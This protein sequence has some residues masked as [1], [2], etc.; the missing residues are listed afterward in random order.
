MVFVVSS[1]LSAAP[2]EL[3]ARL[4][5]WYDAG[6]RALPWRPESGG[7]GD[8]YGVWLSEVMLQQ[9]TVAAVIPYFTKFLERWPTL[10]DLA[11]AADADV[12]T[13]WAGLGYYSRAR[14]VLACARAVVAEHEGRFPEDVASLRTLPGIGPYTAAAVSAIAFGRREAAVDGNV[15]R[16]VARL[17]DDPTPLPVFKKTARLVTVL[18]VPEDRPG[19]FAQAAMELGAMVC[20]PRNP[21]CA[22]CPWGDSCRAR[23]AGTVAVRPNR[24]PK[25]N[26]PHRHGVAFWVE[27]ETPQGHEVW[28]IRRPDKG[29]L[30]GMFAFPCSDW[31]PG[32]GMPTLMMPDAARNWLVTPLNQPVHHVFTHFALDLKVVRVQ[33]P[34]LADPTT[35]FGSG[36]WVRV[37]ALEGLPT[38]M[39][40]VRRAVMTGLP[41]RP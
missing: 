33:V 25:A 31:V 41:P 12:M 40:K 16:V 27:R 6:H 21:D 15:E 35:A 34:D 22:A 32:D 13:A 28:L 7:L 23:V 2:T 19:D 17:L 1:A 11:A 29:L 9:T 10:A 3:A 38:V 8:P 26:K 20:R 36:V 14:N 30:G 4:L 18:L 37:G 5:A 39:D 24:P